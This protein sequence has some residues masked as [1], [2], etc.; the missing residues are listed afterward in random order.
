L[1]DLYRSNDLL[2]FPSLHDS[3]GNVVIE[4]MSF[5]LPVICLDIGGPKCFVDSNTGRVIQTAGKGRRQIEFA[6]ASAM[7]ELYCSPDLLAAMSKSAK[8]FADSHSYEMQIER[9]SSL[10]LSKVSRS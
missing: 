4:A 5:G 8:N 9:V 7:T 1:F 2:V 3:G 6:I 10:A